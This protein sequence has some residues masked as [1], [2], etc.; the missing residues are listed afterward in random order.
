MALWSIYTDV[1][2]LRLHTDG[3]C[4]MDLQLVMYQTEY[5]VNRQFIRHDHIGLIRAQISWRH[6][7]ELAEPPLTNGKLRVD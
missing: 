3:C 1:E 2:A 6:V 4:W 7:Q 5:R